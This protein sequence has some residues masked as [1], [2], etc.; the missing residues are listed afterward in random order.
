MENHRR[1]DLLITPKSFVHF[2][3]QM[4]TSKKQFQTQCTSTCANETAT[5]S[6]MYYGVSVSFFCESP[7]VLHG[8]VQSGI[9]A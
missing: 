5:A 2:P 4:A 6:M 9:L 8:L 1:L 3:N 7:I